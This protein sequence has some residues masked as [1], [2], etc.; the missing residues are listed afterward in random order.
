MKYLITGVK[1][2]FGKY[3]YEKFGGFGLTRQNAGELE[4]I[5]YAETIIHCAFNKKESIQQ[6][7]L[8]DYIQDNIFLTK[9][10]LKIPHKKFVFLSSVNVYPKNKKEHSED[11]KINLNDVKTIYGITKLMS[12]SLIIKESRNPLI[13][14]CPN[15]LGPYSNNNINRLIKKEPI[16]LS[17]DSVLNLILYDDVVSFILGDYSGIYN[18]ASLENITF[19]EISKILNK[20]EIT[21]GNFHYN[22]G[23]IDNSK[24]GFKKTSKEVFLD[25]LKNCG[26]E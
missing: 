23:K 2:G 11:E 4:K 8:S 24:C 21:F 17:E 20:K 1:N 3:I 19:F 12:E 5:T 25:F 13:L 15:L 7:E 26:C 14:R 22:V 6:K 18:L 9:K 16:T 10:L